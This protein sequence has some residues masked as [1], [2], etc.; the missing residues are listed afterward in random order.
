MI[1]VTGTLSLSRS[2]WMWKRRI[3]PLDLLRLLNVQL[4]RCY[5]HIE[6]HTLRAIRTHMHVSAT[7]ARSSILHGTTLAHARKKQQSPISL[8]PIPR[9]IIPSKIFCCCCCW[10]VQNSR[11]LRQ[12]NDVPGMGSVS[13]NSVA[14]TTRY[15]YSYYYYTYCRKSK[16]ASYCLY[17]CQVV[18]S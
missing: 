8:L 2:L 18:F 16:R 9:P 7:A 6:R 11:S 1:I 13:Q 15:Y 3:Q 14:T 12:R 10:P 4:L 5:E 17:L